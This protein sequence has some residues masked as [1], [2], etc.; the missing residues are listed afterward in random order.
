MKNELPVMMRAL[1]L[2]NYEGWRTGLCLIEKPVPRPKPGQVLV[3]IGASP[4]NPA[5]LAFVS[6]RYGVRRPLPTVPGWEGSG[7]VVTTG[8]GLMARFLLGRRVACAAV[9]GSDGAWAEY[10]VTSP[11]RCIPLRKHVTTE[12]GATLLVNPLSAWAMMDLVRRG[13]HRALVQTAAAGA[14]G[15]M[16]YRLSRRVSLPTINIVRRPEQVELLRSIGVE[17]VLN[18]QAPDFDERLSQLCEQLKATVALDAVA[19]EMTHRLLQAMPRRAE[20]MVYGALS[21]QPCQVSPGQLIFKRQRVRGFWLSTWKPRF[22][23]LGMLYAGWQI[24]TLLGQELKTEIQDRVP[25]SEAISGMER[26]VN[27]MTEGKILLLPG[28][29]PI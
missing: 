25:L 28:D 19:G 9:D 7:Q 4:V 18:S 13:G 27:Q 24:Q 6:G 12:Q 8:G 17:H 23:M 26:Y 10:M 5:D 29:S 3:K 2:Q 14:L 20:I 15:R 1:E 11:L 22:G 16:L 21:N